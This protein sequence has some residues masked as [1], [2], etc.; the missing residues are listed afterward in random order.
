MLGMLHD[1]QAPIMHEKETEE[2]LENDMSF[3]SGVEQVTM[4]ILQGY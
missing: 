3:N 2:G 4:N 1:L